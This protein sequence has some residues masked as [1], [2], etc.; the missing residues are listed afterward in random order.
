M[1]HQRL[2]CVYHIRDDVPL[3]AESLL[4][5]YNW[6]HNPLTNRYAYDVHG[7]TAMSQESLDLQVTA[8]EQVTWVLAHL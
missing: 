7:L 2:H 5:V 3:S 6:L 4:Y 1:L 8:T